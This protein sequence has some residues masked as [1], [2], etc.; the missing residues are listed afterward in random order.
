MRLPNIEVKLTLL[1][2]S[3]GDRKKPLFL[4]KNEA[5]YRPHIVIGDASQ[6]ELIIK[7]W[8]IDR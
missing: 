4:D 5:P 8:Q 6:K 1:T 3:E 2:K 7:K